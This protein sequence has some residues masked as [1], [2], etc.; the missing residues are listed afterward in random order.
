MPTRTINVGPSDSSQEL[1]LDLTQ[2]N[3]GDYVT[4]SYCWGQLN[5]VKTTRANIDDHKRVIPYQTFPRTMRDAITIT[6]KLVKKFLWI[7]AL[8]II[9]DSL[10]DED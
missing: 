8:C 2:D 9:Q 3:I 6:R 7:N 5:N 4:L 1:Y 10:N